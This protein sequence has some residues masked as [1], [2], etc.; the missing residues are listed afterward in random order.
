MITMELLDACQNCSNFE[1]I[2]T[3]TYDVLYGGEAEHHCTVTCESI[4]KC[5]AL[6]VYL[7]KEEKNNGR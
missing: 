2:K 6:L 7:R 1:P 4:D 3:G 5:R